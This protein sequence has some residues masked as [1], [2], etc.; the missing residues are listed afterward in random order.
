MARRDIEDAMD[1][2]MKDAFARAYT[3][4]DLKAVQAYEAHCAETGTTPDDA[5]RREWVLEW[6]DLDEED[7]LD[8][9]EAQREREGLWTPDWDGWGP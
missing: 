2:A 1:G 3:G 6:R 7:R 9:L 8:A 5:G 4:R